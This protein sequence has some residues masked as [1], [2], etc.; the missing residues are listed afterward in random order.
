MSE[1]ST[2]KAINHAQLATETGDATLIVVDD[3]TNRLV[4]SEGLTQTALRSAVTNHTADPLW[5]NDAKIR[6][7]AEKALA[8]L[9][10]IRDSSGNLSSAQLSNAARLFARVLI[11]LV[12]LSLS[13]FDGVD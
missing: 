5:S 2:T 3:G 13:R 6:D 8:D 10:T 7:Q 4:R 11:V 1:V 12:R 9:R